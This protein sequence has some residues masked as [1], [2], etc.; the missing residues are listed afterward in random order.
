MEKFARSAGIAIVVLGGVG[1][2]LGIIFVTQ[3]MAMIGAANIVIGIALILAGLMLHRI[4][5]VF[6]TLFMA[7]KPESEPAA[8]GKTKTKIK[9]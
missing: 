4:L 2:V 1:F 8:K 5:G 3:A 6:L 9:R 7:P